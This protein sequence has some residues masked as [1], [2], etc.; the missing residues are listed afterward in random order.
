MKKI[1]VSLTVLSALALT[2]C[3]TKEMTLCDCLGLQDK[4]DSK[5]DAVKDLGEEQVK[6]CEEM[7]E[8]ATEEEMEKCKK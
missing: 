1:I 8:K 6:K 3:G 7:W 5:K 2:S 4:Y